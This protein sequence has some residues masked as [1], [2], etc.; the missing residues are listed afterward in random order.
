[1]PQ[2]AGLAPTAGDSGEA[3]IATAIACPSFVAHRR[4]ESAVDGDEL[5]SLI[6][7]IYDAAIAPSLW[8]G[9]LAK[10]A[11]F[12]GGEAAALLSKDAAT[13]SGSVYYD[14]GGSD[15]HFKQLYFETYIKVDPTTAGQCFAEV[16]KPVSNGDIIP[17][18][19][20]FRS[21]F[22]REWLRPQRL[23]DN[24][25]VALDRSATG[26]ALFSVF[27]HERHGL[28]DDEVRRRVGFIAPHVRRAALVGWTIDHR[29][30]EASTLADSLDGLTAG[31]FL[32]GEGSRIVHANAAGQT[33]L[34][35]GCVLRSVHG[36]L[37][38]TDARATRALQNVVVRAGGSDA[39]LGVGGIAVPMT[40][41]DGE[42]YVAHALPLT[43][44]ARRRA[45]ASDAA[46]AALFVQ[47]AV[48]GAP[49]APEVI[50]QTFKLTPSEL[51]VLLASVE[52]GG[53]P[54]IAE[55]LGIGEA[56]VKTHLHRLFRKTAT[57]RR[58]QLVKLVAGFS[59]P[60]V[61]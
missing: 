17:Y 55:A 41:R 59:S 22:Y 45:S 56:T 9:V 14:C 20:L 21:R 24:V 10:A 47:R 54:E 42:H 49:S 28:V 25:S 48:V 5:S 12:V 27:R 26:A 58:A 33:M 34:A 52:G 8:P 18:D 38:P 37:A 4:A 31:M 32:L 16:G 23:I 6:G 46:V 39:A 1:M 2:L 11:E 50:A 19:E 60:L 53:V 51:R 36:K 35:Q 30:A 7:E 40:A 61:G 57:R 15:P 13:R 29:A 3:G 43:S 44:A